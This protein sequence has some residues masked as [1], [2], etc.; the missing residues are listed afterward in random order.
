[1]PPEQKVTP[2]LLTLRRIESAAACSSGASTRPP[3]NLILA[4]LELSSQEA[5]GR[6]L[7][8]SSVIVSL[9][10][11]IFIQLAEVSNLVPNFPMNLTQIREMRSK[12]CYAKLS[13]DSIN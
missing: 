7:L 2:R 12:L 6:L 9:G 8:W 4:S 10:S 1:M 3:V 11:I 13:K 5:E